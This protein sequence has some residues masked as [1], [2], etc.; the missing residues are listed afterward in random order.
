M[1]F[2]IS[3]ASIVIHVCKITWFVSLLLIFS[4]QA[5]PDI[6]ESINQVVPEIAQSIN[7][8]T[9]YDGSY[10]VSFICDEIYMANATIDIENGAIKGQIIQNIKQQTFNVSGH[11]TEK[12][13]IKFQAITTY[14]KEPV[15]AVG[16]INDDGM[17]QGTYRVG[18]RNCE[19]I[20]FCFTKNKNEIVT[21]Y[22]GVYNLD[23]ISGGKHIA[24]FKARIENGE[25]HSVLMNI[26]NNTYKID[27]KVSKN[28][29][30]ILNTLFSN[31]NKG[32]TVIG[33]IQKDF[34]VKGIYTTYTG[35]KGAFSG[36][37]IDD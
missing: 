4:C 5:V 18:N 32:L 11:V 22:D 36:K 3:P 15:E 30:L 19:F 27:G 35:I 34:S 23:L 14:T 17:I 13:K 25:F 33:Y 21:Q 1:P 20:G 24:N 9:Q 12:G 6:A 26:N 2:A 29:R 31:M 16:A 37:K 8:K 10:T 28:G 7:A